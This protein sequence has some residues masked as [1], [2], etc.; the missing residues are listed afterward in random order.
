MIFFCVSMIYAKKN[1]IQNKEAPGW[2]G[3]FRVLHNT[4]KKGK[5]VLQGETKHSIEKTL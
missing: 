3:H 2:V 4:L 1:A 5:G